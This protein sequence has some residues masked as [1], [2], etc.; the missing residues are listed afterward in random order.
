MDGSLHIPGVKYYGIYVDSIEA[1]LTEQEALLAQKGLSVVQA[2]EELG[3]PLSNVATYEQAMG[4]VN[5]RIEY[6]LNIRAI[7]ESQNAQF[8]PHHNVSN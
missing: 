1:G 4:D 7:Q 5:S 2:E 3:Q 6:D 8:G